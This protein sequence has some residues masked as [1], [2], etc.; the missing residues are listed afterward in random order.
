V[1]DVRDAIETFVPFAKR[2]GWLGRR[3]AGLIT[4]TIGTV[5]MGLVAR[6]KV[7]V[8]QGIRVEGSVKPTSGE[9]HLNT[10][11]SQAYD[12]LRRSNMITPMVWAWASYHQRVR[13][14]VTQT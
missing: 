2:S 11:T 10:P 3:V 13:S 4:S 9:L 7:V 8:M 6:P 1:I 5:V 14:S 12:Q